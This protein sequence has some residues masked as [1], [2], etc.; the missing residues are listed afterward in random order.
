MFAFNSLIRIFK[1]KMCSYEH[2]KN[3]KSPRSTVREYVQNLNKTTNKK[4]KMETSETP[5]SIIVGL[6]QL[7]N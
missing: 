4:N 2:L 1:K 3:G 5:Y 6:K 7:Q